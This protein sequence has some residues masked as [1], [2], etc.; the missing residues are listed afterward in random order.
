MSAG[1]GPTVW[2]LFSPDLLAA[3]PHAI[4]L[5]IYH[6]IGP[7]LLTP[8]SHIM[9]TDDTGDT[10][11]GKLFRRGDIGGFPKSASLSVTCYLTCPQRL[12]VRLPLLLSRTSRAPHIPLL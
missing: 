4:D 3:S 11:F 10:T 7:I 8:L 9:V 6:A 2:G 1:A 5:A 12:S